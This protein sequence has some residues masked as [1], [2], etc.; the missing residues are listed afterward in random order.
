MN[1]AVE[2]A[3]ETYNTLLNEIKAQKEPPKTDYQRRK[4]YRETSPMDYQRRI[5][6]S[7]DPQSAVSEAIRE[8][9]ARSK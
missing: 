8:I 6:M 1:K 7:P 3:R 4:E 5:A 9:I 2:G